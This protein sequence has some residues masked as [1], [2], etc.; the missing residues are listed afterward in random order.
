ML[1]DWDKVRRIGRGQGIW[2]Y[3]YCKLTTPVRKS[4]LSLQKLRTLD[5]TS[6]GSGRNNSASDGPGGS[7]AM[8]LIRRPMRGIE[9]LARERELWPSFFKSWFH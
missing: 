1:R 9:Y 7:G 8:A 6:V 5:S 3:S 4:A 2:Q